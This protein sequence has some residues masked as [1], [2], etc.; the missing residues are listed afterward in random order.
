VNIVI[1]YDKKKQGIIQT[2]DLDIIREH[3]SVADK[4]AGIK[5]KYSR[6]APTR[7]YVI[8]P[9]GRFDIGL[10]PEI[11][12][13]IQSL[14][15]PYKLLVT[16][17]FKEQFF[18]G[19]DK[20]CPDELNI[21]LRDYQQECIEKCIKLGRGTVRI[22]TA[23]G[24]T[25]VMATLI[26]TVKPNK[27]IVIVPG[28]QLVEQTYNDFVEYGLQDV[29]KWDG[30]N[31]LDPNSKVIVV[32]ANILYSKTQD[33][34]ILDQADL[35]LVDEVHKLKRGS[36]LSKIV[37]KIPTSHRFGFT[38]SMPEDLLDEW[39]ILGK[40]GPV[41]YTK[42]SK[43]LRDENFISNLKIQ[44]LKLKYKEPLQY[45]VIP[46]MA[47][48]TAM[49]EEEKEFV[50][51]HPFRN[52]VIGTLCDKLDQNVLVLVDRIDHQKLLTEE[53]KRYAP[54]KEV[55][56]IRGEVDVDAREEIRKL[57]EKKS[58]VVCIAMS[59]IFSTGINIKNLHY[60]IFAAGGKAKVRT[61]QTIG[62]GLRLHDDKEK[63][64]IFD[65][66]DDLIYS[67]RH[68]E[69]RIQIYEKE[70]IYYERRETVE[71]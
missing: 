31:K 15:V 57:M 69:K 22:A 54:E 14:N 71:R 44:I 3:F 62:R 58:N 64:I 50:Y 5:K 2:N 55:H 6:W 34:S 63:L 42:T 4:Q 48:P 70:Q 29:S 13:Y 66:A 1:D 11:Y 40:I 8:T 12:S 35:L 49:Y 18:I 60:I 24:K 20:N 51:N 37:D 36:S 39:N 43:E 53:V 32:G 28:A 41:V 17:K 45:S 16:D 30:N 26:N 21:S 56:F 47:N 61:I 33:K 19:Y 27:C 10:F 25:L 23:G 46:S 59:A 52:K 67:N 65:L 68:V 38:G 9:S 7:K